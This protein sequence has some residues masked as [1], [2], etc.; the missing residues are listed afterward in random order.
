MLDKITPRNLFLVDSLGALVSAILLGIV[1]VQLEKVI[2]MPR[3]TLFVLAGL[4][5]VF[6]VFSLSNYIFFG[7]NWRTFLRIIAIVNILYCCI[8]MYLVFFQHQLTTLGVIY[9]LGEVIIIV[10]LAI[11]ELKVANTYN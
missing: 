7:K 4:A 10:A 11:F 2:G 8:T 1:L 3:Q 5:L 9:F 6:F